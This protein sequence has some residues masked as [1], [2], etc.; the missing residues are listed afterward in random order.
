MYCQN[1][2]KN[3]ATIHLTEISDGVRNEMH[4]CETCAG[5]QGI[6]IKSSLPINELLGNLLSSAP[7][8]EELFGTTDKDSVCPNCGMTIDQYRKE[9]MLGCP[10]DYQ[11][12]E[13]TLLPLIKKA[14]NGQTHHCDKTPS[15]MPQETKHQV[16]LDE[17]RQRLE[18][19]VK[20]E[21]YELA[22]KLRDKIAAYEKLPH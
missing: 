9:G 15:K 21:N 12:F 4:L 10:Q 5:E 14:H 13:E 8:D 22:A 19:A 20:S 11:V 17:L 2:K 18:V 1:C 6:T 16:E 3:E 7:P